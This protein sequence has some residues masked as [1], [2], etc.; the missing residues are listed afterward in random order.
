M[1]NGGITIGPII[2]TMASA[3]KERELWFGS[4]L[5][6]WLME[7]L[8]L[9]MKEA[10]YEI[11]VPIATK[12]I[13][14]SAVGSFSDRLMFKIPEN[15]I[16]T[17]Q[18]KFE[19]IYKAY[20]TK[21]YGIYSKIVELPSI[22]ESKL[23][24]FKEEDII[25]II[26]NYLQ[27]KCFALKSE[28]LIEEAN[29]YLNNAELTVATSSLTSELPCDRCRTLPSTVVVKADKGSTKSLYLCPICAIKYGAIFVTEVREKTGIKHFPSVQDIAA[30]EIKEQLQKCNMDDDIEE[31]KL[32]LILEGQKYYSYFGVLYMDMDNTAK[33]LDRIK[34]DKEK[35]QEFSKKISEFC[36]ESAR[37]IKDY[38]GQTIYAAGDDVLA[39][40]PVRNKKAGDQTLFNLVQS[41]NGKFRE[42]VTLAEA[43]SPLSLSFGISI[44]FIKSPLKDALI[45]ALD[46]LIG[47]A[48]Q[49]R[50]TL[51]ISVR[52]HA[53]AK[54]DVRCPLDKIDAYTNIFTAQM[55]GEL[56]LEG[57]Y[58]AFADI[59]DRLVLVPKSRIKHIL[60]NHFDEE[61]HSLR[62][63]QFQEFQEFLEGIINEDADIDT[64]KK[65]VMN[66][67]N[68]L[69]LAKLL[70]E[71]EDKGSKK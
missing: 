68:L 18:E 39:L 64:K 28:I 51:Y 50:N 65:Q 11:I 59:I 3:K 4:Y 2:D 10:G 24:D 55:Q 26:R 54:F 27:V 63:K 19:E 46:A 49:T 45:S 9:G 57:S 58:Q 33:Y 5:F 6:S 1:I 52:K 67:V 22:V 8:Y 15:G 36:T 56:L 35:I 17:S 37:I 69:R 48:K 41:L 43:D 25:E 70:E 20:P 53:G 60:K 29:T 21:L 13:G 61:E 47:E 23:G 71:K 38:G 62:K 30:V 44:Q 34:E 14:E 7:D 66:A 42:T 31:S 12:T 16:E 32:K 40:V